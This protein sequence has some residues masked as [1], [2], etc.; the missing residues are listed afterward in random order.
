MPSF[1]YINSNADS[2]SHLAVEVHKLAVQRLERR[3]RAAG[4]G[5]R[6]LEAL[7]ADDGI[8]LGGGG[9]SGGGG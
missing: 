5:Q 9:G 1:K 4:L 8:L 7:D 6:R 3:P 2:K